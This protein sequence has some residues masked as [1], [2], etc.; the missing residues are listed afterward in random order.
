M[1]IMMQN[2]HLAINNDFFIVAQ[3]CHVTISNGINFQL[4]ATKLF[5]HCILI[6]F[7]DP[8][9]MIAP[10]VEDV[11]AFDFTQVLFKF[12]L[13]SIQA[14]ITKMDQNVFWPH[15]AVDYLE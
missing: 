2:N 12:F 13:R 11:L 7:S 3:K 10:D 1:R 15:K 9:V 8:A 6:Y 5:L 14:K 4:S